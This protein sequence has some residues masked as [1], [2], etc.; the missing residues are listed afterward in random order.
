MGKA[1]IEGLLGNKKK[2]VPVGFEPTRNSAG[3]LKSSPLTTRA[4]YFST[5]LLTSPY[6]YLS[7]LLLIII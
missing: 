1:W 2:V 5:P 7:F 4:Q 3:D 6:F